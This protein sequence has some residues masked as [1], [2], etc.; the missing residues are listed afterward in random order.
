MHQLII[1]EPGTYTLLNMGDPAMMQIALERIGELWPL[2]ATGVVTGSPE[3]LSRL[4]P[5]V[6]PL[7][8]RERDAWLFGREPATRLLQRLPAA[9]AGIIVN[10]E[11][12]AWLR[13]PRVNDWAV[14]MKARLMGRELVEPDCFRRRLQ[15][16]GLLAVTG[17]GVLNDDFAGN[18]MRLLDEMEAALETGIPVAAFGQGIGPMTDAALRQRARAVLPRLTLISLR[19]G[20]SGLPLLAELGV[21]SERILVTGDDAI[22]LAFRRRPPSTGEAIGINLRLAPYAGTDDGIIDRLSEPLRDVAARTRRALVPVSISLYK[23]ESDAEVVERMLGLQSPQPSSRAESP[24]DVIRSIAGCRV[25]VAGSYH[26]GVFALAMGIPV[27]ALIS[28]PYYEQKFKGLAAQFPG[29]CRLLDLRRPLGSGE[30]QDA[31]LAALE[32]AGSIRE[33]LLREAERQ[34]E[35]SREA[36]RAV[37]RLCTLE[38]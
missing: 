2:A 28:S 29:G 7:D 25:V 8:V 3:R 16:A 17:M 14:R 19:E 5:H 35:L 22:E 9:L 10:L 27:V 4:S 21:A 30:V 1:V 37:R 38:S 20:V 36:Y 31:I 12:R 34:V 6:V 24:E 26:A 23:H 33:S 15:E 18:A 11:R 32:S 13:L